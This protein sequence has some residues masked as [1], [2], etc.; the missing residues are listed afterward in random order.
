MDTSRRSSVGGEDPAQGGG[1]I[2][3][4][5]HDPLPVGG[6]AVALI[7]GTCALLELPVSGPLLVAAG[8][9][10]ALVYG[11]DRA[12]SP[13]P[14]DR[15]NRPDRVA[16]VQSHQRWLVVEGIVLALVGGAALWLL[17]P[18]TLL[19]AGALAGVAALHLWPGDGGGPLGRMGMGKPLVVAGVWAAGATVL[20]AVEAGVALGGEVGLLVAYRFLFVLPNTLLSDWGD[21]AGDRAAGLE[22]WTGQVGGA[23][24]RRVATGLLVGALGVAVLGVGTVGWPPTLMAVDAV[25]VGLLLGAAWRLDPTRSRHRL[26]LDGLVAWPAVTALAAWGLG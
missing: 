16:W 14:E 2:E 20:P 10:A 3:A 23:T 24:V 1:G 6:V 19:T 22:P 8:C 13:S 12:L 15:W 18:A 11:A 9:G 7:L 4:A 26:A 5:C 17:R 25:G 21:R